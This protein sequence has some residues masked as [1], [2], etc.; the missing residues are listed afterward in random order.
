VA[1]AQAGI[2]LA[3]ILASCEELDA[4]PSRASSGSATAPVEAVALTRTEASDV[5]C[6]AIIHGGVSSI[7]EAATGGH[8]L[9]IAQLREATSVHAHDKPG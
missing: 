7:A 3:E 4:T 5:L 6:H 2:S 8:A 9:A 1:P